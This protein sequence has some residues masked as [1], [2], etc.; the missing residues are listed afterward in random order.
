MVS[1]HR[2]DPRAASTSAVACQRRRRPLRRPCLVHKRVKHAN[3]IAPA[4]D[5]GDNRIGQS[6]PLV[7]Q[8]GFDFASNDALKVA[9]ERRKRVRTNG[10]PNNVVRRL[11]VRDPV[12][13]RFVHGILKRLG[14]A[15]DDNH[16]C[17]QHL[18][19]KD[20]ER[21]AL[22]IDISHVHDT[23]ETEQGTRR[24][25]GHTM[26][27]RA[28]LCNNARLAQ[29]L[30]QHGLLQRIVNLVG[31]RVVQVLALEPNLRALRMLREPTGVG[32]RRL[33][34]NIV[35]TQLLEL[36]P[37][38]RVLRRL[39]VRVNAVMM[40]LNERLGDKTATK[41]PKHVADYADYPPSPQK[42]LV[43]G[44][45]RMYRTPMYHIGI[46]YVMSPNR[47]RSDTGTN[48]SADINGEIAIVYYYV[49][50]G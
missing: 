44:K 24:G 40:R 50:S 32:Q 30:G 22:R 42:E 15:R 38:A 31:A 6:S 12:P 45:N 18:H 11:D 20:I 39:H 26:L 33:T 19:A 13:N 3:G 41:L 16:F 36:L 8:L 2:I 5:T 47:L 34:A 43:R 10:R 37:K 48:L 28:R 7:V 14:P 4:A 17:S 35:P 23:V 27:P 25:R 9:H 21:R 1:G 46:L 29:P 49:P